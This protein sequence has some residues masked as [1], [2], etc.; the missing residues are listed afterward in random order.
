[1]RKLKKINAT[2]YEADFTRARVEVGDK[3]R[4][5]KIESKSK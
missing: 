2:T 3:D 4:K 1:M 5:A